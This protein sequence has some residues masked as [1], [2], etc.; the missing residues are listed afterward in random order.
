MK[1]GKTVGIVLAVAVA[2]VLLASCEG[3]GEPAA[4]K[5]SEAPE[6]EAPA[7]PA[8][9]VPEAP[10]PASGASIMRPEVSAEV[11]AE[12]PAPGPLPPPTQA[13]VRFPFGDADLDEEAKEALHSLLPAARD[14]AAIT[15]RGHT[16]SHGSDRANHRVS[17]ARAEAVRDYLAGNGVDPE[18]MSVVALGE[19]RPVA[20][21]AT[22]EGADDEEG[23]SRNRRVVVVV[24]PMEEQATA[25]AA[26]AS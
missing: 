20:P 7:I 10:P 17:L 2:G 19:A 26:D 13:E 5:A 21:N 3:G 23:R 24:T 8:E 1:S 16:D 18:I 12:A 11:P 22:L 6:P 15:I 14:A 25:P 4:R 9:Q